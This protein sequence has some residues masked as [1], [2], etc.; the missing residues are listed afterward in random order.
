MLG[1]SPKTFDAVDMPAIAIRKLILPMFD[2]KMFF[3]ANINK[4]VIATPSIGVDNRC[5]P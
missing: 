2:T 4:S 1:I 3:I 5:F